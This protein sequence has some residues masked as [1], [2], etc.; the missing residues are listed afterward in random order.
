MTPNI[1]TSSNPAFDA[2]LLGFLAAAQA[3]ID[4]G[5]AD[6]PHQSA[7]LEVD[8]GTKFLR[9]VE[10]KWY[11]GEQS[12]NRSVYVFIEKATGN[13]LKAA[14]WRAPERKNPRSNIFSPD[15]GASG[16]TK[17]GAIYLR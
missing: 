13:I 14:S 12:D 3:K 2:A 10:V 1:P 15:F 11:N 8:A 17:Y 9:I 5:Y 6:S 7:T 4:E 16:V